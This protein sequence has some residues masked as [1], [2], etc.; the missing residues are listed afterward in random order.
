[1]GQ[2]AY[3]YTQMKDDLEHLAITKLDDSAIKGTLSFAGR[4]LKL[5][6][7]DDGEGSIDIKH[8]DVTIS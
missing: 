7:E 5:N 8:D 1:M 2:T 4:G 6:N 3:S